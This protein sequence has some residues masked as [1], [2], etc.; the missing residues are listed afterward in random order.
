MNENFTVPFQMIGRDT[1]P[2]R[3]VWGYE[4]PVFSVAAA[5][6]TYAVNNV[7][8]NVA[9][10]AAGY[11]VTPVG[12]SA[13]VT[14]LAYRRPSASPRSW[15]QSKSDAILAKHMRSHVQAL[16]AS[17]P[18]RAPAWA[19]RTVPLPAPLTGLEFV[20]SLG[21]H[22]G[23]IGLYTT[24]YKSVTNTPRLPTDPPG[25][26]QNTQCLNVVGTP[27][28]YWVQ[29]IGGEAFFI[30]LFQMIPGSPEFAEGHAIY[31]YGLLRVSAASIYETWVGATATK[32]L[33]NATLVDAWALEFDPQELNK[34]WL[35]GS[36][37]KQTIVDTLDQDQTLDQQIYRI[38]GIFTLYNEQRTWS[39]NGTYSVTP[40][41]YQLSGAGFN[42]T[43]LGNQAFTAASNTAST[44]TNS[45]PQLGET[46]PFDAESSTTVGGY[47]AESRRWIQGAQSQIGYN[48][49]SAGSFSSENGYTC[50]GVT[51]GENSGSYTITTGNMTKQW[52]AQR[53]PFF[54]SYDTT[55]EVL[56]TPPL[57][58]DVQEQTFTTPPTSAYQ[59]GS[60]SVEWFDGAYCPVEQPSIIETNN[61]ES[62]ITQVFHLTHGVA[63]T[64]PPQIMLSGHILIFMA[65]K[66]GRLG[67]C[68]VRVTNTSQ[69]STL[70]NQY[71]AAVKDSAEFTTALNSMIALM[72]IKVNNCAP[73]QLIAE[74][75]PSKG[76]L[77]FPDAV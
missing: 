50:Q 44:S 13:A 60:S 67:L 16:V 18:G 58:D 66:N 25:Q 40:S 64:P 7:V 46:S 19:A 61:S 34:E 29:Y 32:R 36:T 6:E 54:F 57:I 73:T 45:R 38:V 17:H 31:Q 62:D 52:P 63:L 43:S 10:T 65:F 24:P 4:R 3:L 69:W 1:E 59:T 27:V 22:E 23:A 12:L 42:V 76:Y 33:V 26:T 49:R 53:L 56:L 20:M 74:L 48:I 9:E 47:T 35:E 55:A 71:R 2:V 30:F 70:R 15:L 14:K 72:D 51:Y 5:H 11:T 8:T 77:M 39:I 68:I 28:S 41:I 37:L 75:E 21:A